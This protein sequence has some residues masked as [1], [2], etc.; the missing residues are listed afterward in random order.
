VSPALAKS[1]AVS[2]SRRGPTAL[3][4]SWKSFSTPGGDEIPLLRLVARVLFGGADPPVADDHGLSLRLFIVERG[5]REL[6]P[7]DRL[8]TVADACAGVVV[9]EA[10]DDLDA[11]LPQRLALLRAAA[12]GLETDSGLGLPPSGV[13]PHS[14]RSTIG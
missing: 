6:E 14:T 1:S 11:R 13:S 3:V 9:F 10:H 7:R 8:L 2:S 5:E 12:D 4:F